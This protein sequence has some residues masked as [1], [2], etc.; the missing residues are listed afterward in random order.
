MSD[1]MQNSVKICD[2]LQQGIQIP[3][4]LTWCYQSHVFVPDLN[5]LYL[6]FLNLFVNLIKDK[7]ERELLSVRKTKNIINDNVNEI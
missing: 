1:Q 6:N 7:I 2:S 3:W 5:S 4:L